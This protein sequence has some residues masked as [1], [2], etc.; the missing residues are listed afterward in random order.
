MGPRTGRIV[1]RSGNE[2]MGRGMAGLA[3]KIAA[4]LF[5]AM[6]PIQSAL[7]Q[8]VGDAGAGAEVFKKC[9]VCHRVGVGAK[10]GVG[11]VLN[12]IVGRP[13]GTYEGYNYSTA[14]KTSG[15]TWDVKTLTVYLKSPKELVPNTKM[16]FVGLSTPKEIADIIAYLSQFDAEGNIKK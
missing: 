15:L 4:S 10:I 12:G 1:G 9:G 16:A 7:A 13:A 3:S 8:E 5:L 2:A 11:P 14:N 6:L